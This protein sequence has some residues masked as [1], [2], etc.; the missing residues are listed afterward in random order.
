[1]PVVNFDFVL[2]TEID[3]GSWEQPFLLSDRQIF[4][5]YLFYPRQ[6]DLRDVIKL[7]SHTVIKFLQKIDQSYELEKYGAISQLI[8]I[9]CEILHSCNVDK[10]VS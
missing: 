1:M 10:K 5:N 9:L 7:L 2:P 6:K 4:Y 8:Q 3:D